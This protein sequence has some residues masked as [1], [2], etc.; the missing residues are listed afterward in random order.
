MHMATKKR[1][2]PNKSAELLD[3]GARLASKYGEQN[4]TRRMVAEEGKVS[5]PLVSH[6]FGGTADAQKK[7]ARRAKALGLPLPKKAEA[8]E[9][10]RELR[11]KARSGTVGKKRGPYKKETKP[12]KK[13]VT[14]GAS[15]A[16]KAVT[17]TAGTKDATPSV[18]RKKFAPPPP[19]P[20]AAPS[21]E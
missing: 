19:P 16:R 18:P 11:R 8:M 15:G 7:Y 5:E 17:R 6:F 21:K 12:A 14:A 2:V 20:L 13:S 9:L 10:G 1:V 4:I 3:I